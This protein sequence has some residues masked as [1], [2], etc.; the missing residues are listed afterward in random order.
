[1]PTRSSR[2]DSLAAA[3]SWNPAPGRQSMS[4][5]LGGA[6]VGMDIEKIFGEN[7]FGMAEM[8][9]RL[10]K[11]AYKALCAT[12]ERGHELDPEVADAVALAMK[13]WA[14]EKGATHFTHWFQPLTGVDGREARLVH[15]AERGWR[16]GRRV[17][18]QGAD[19]GRAGRVVVPVGRPA[20]DVRGARLHG[21]GSDV[22]G[23]HRRERE[24]L[25]PRDPDGVRV[26]DRRR[27][28]HEDSAAALDARAR[29]AGAPRA[30]AVRTSS[31]KRVHRDARAGA[32]VLPDRPGVL[33][34]P[35]GPGRR[36]AARCS[37]PSR[38]AGRSSRTTTSAR[39]RSACSPA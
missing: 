18:R 9:A 23:V 31:A 12:I 27:A 6:G 3:R 29:R 13:E 19:P 39:S 15:H 2:F 24:R 32:G 10:P 22:A 38:R 7:T 26:V 17:Q 8:K 28:R 16:R 11:P 21:V 5:S 37:A 25:L 1:M 33:L 30:E 4:G 35:S 34:P 14:L 36:R 20:R